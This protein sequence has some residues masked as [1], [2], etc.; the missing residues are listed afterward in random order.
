MA[1][2]PKFKIDP[3][4]I[5]HI[6][7]KLQLQQPADLIEITPQ[8]REALLQLIHDSKG[9]LYPSQRQTERYDY[10]Y[11]QMVAAVAAKEDDKFEQFCSKIETFERKFCKYICRK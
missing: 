8:Q 6:R 1:L 9:S 7:R 10:I 2:I 3:E 5:C 11:D 4:A